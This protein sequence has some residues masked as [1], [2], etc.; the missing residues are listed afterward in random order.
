MPSP[1]GDSG[2]GAGADVLAAWATR[3]GRRAGERGHVSLRFAFYGRMSTEDWQDPRRRGQ[4]REQAVALVAGP[5]KI[6]AQFFDCEQS[7]ALRGP[8]ALRLRLW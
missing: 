7:R 4:Q 5:G 3:T 2:P 6:V 8:G 1:G